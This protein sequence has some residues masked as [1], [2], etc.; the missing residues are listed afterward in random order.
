MGDLAEVEHDAPCFHRGAT[1]GVVDGPDRLAIEIAAHRHRGE[2]VFPAHARR[3]WTRRRFERQDRRLVVAAGKTVSRSLVRHRRC[4]SWLQKLAQPAGQ[5]LRRFL[6]ARRLLD[7]RPSLWRPDLD[8][9]HRPRP[10]D[11]L[12]QP[13]VFAETGRDEDPA[14]LVDGALLRG[15]DEGAREEAD[16]PIEDG[17]GGDLLR[18]PLPGGGSERDQAG[19]DQVRRDEELV[20]ALGGE[21]LAKSGREAGAPLGVDRVLEDARKHRRSPV[22]CWP[23]TSFHFDPPGADST[24]SGKLSSNRPLNKK[25]AELL[26]VRLAPTRIRWRMRREVV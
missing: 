19:I 8:P 3:A 2:V 21:Q 20:R 14:Q 15:R 7:L 23:S 26:V 11:F 24:T 22:W 4:P 10:G 16:V 17:P 13:D 12:D 18:E 1:H 25:A 9:L 5:V 6:R